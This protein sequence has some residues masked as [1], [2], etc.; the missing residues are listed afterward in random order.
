MSEVV[1]FGVLI[2]EGCFD[3]SAINAVPYQLDALATLTSSNSQSF[4]TGSF[5]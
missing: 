2:T 3:A 4:G 5:C 1:F